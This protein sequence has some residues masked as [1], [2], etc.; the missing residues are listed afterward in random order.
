[1]PPAR[2]LGKESSGQWN[3]SL[4]VEGRGGWWE[5]GG[6]ELAV[7]DCGWTCQEEPGLSSQPGLRYT[8][9]NV[10]G[11]ET[12]DML[13]PGRRQA[14]GLQD[15]CPA[16][17]PFLQGSPPLVLAARTHTDTHTHTDT[18]THFIFGAGCGVLV[19]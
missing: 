14:G 13:E 17:R 1:M 3:F 6:W 8:V 10:V 7:S 19:P 5:G 16:H 12:C 11:L 18:G 2:P 15:S 9:W 4:L